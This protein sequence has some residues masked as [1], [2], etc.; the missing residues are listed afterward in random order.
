MRFFTTIILSLMLIVSVSADVN[1]T[2]RANTAFVPDILNAE[3]SVQL[4]GSLPTLTWDGGSPVIF[5]N[6][7]G[8][9]WE[10]T[11]TLPD[12]TVGVYK[13]Y[14]N[15][16]PGIA[17][18][19]EWEHAGWEAGADRPLDLS[20][21]SGT[22]TTL[23]LQ[24]VNGFN[25]DATQFEVP[26]ETND[27]TYAFHI[28]VNMAGWEDFNPENH[29]VAIRGSNMSDWGQTGE[30]SW[31]PSFPLTVEAPHA[32]GGSQNYNAANFYSGTVHVPNT[33]ADAGVQFKFVVHNTGA[34]LG[35]DWGLMAYNTSVDY[36][37]ATTGADT[38][39]YWKWFDNLEPAG[40]SGADTVDV[41]FQA[42]LTKA[43]AGNG[44]SIGDSII[45][46]AGYF[47]TAEEVM[48]LGLVRQGF[49]NVYAVTVEDMVVD[50]NN[51]TGLYYQYYKSSGGVEF[52]EVYFN[53]AYEGNNNSEAERRNI[54][55]TAD[56]Q[57]IADDMDSNVDSR[58]QPVFQN[59]GILSQNVEV[60][61]TLDLRPAYW[62]V[63]NGKTLTDGQGGLHITNHEQIDTMGVS[64]NGPATG[65]WTSWGGELHNT[66]AKQLWDDGTHGD[67]V[68][69]DSVY[70]V[71]FTYGPD[72][73]QNTIGQEFKFGIGGGDNESGYGLNHIENIDD[74]QATFTMAN[75][76]GSI[77]PVFYGWWDYDTNT[78]L[79]VTSV[80]DVVGPYAFQL[81]QNY[82]NP[83]NPT[84][85]ID[86]TVASAGKVELVV[87]NAL[88]QEVR[89]L[90]SSNVTPGA[91][92]VNW[93][94]LDNA[95]LRVSSGLYIYKITNGTQSISKKML[96]LK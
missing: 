52:R 14:T 41:T 64:M 83:F 5:T 48:S 16:Q 44:F 60:T 92:S 62:H 72:S 75:S 59:T 57:V 9:Y 93:N 40:F 69:D 50:L 2:F 13:H 24:Y 67:M 53:F 84:T 90:A 74:A 26:F 91:Y 19:V 12:S 96:M 55:L 23:P 94:G 46:R 85:T 54:V 33:Y 28:R 51:A 25:G 70:A 18:G 32:N 4:R 21:F 36:P 10:V 29:V 89:H 31:G 8:D 6:V 63:L 82:P 11:V 87:Y 77:N 80:D 95:G 37:N 79:A 68:A 73:T 15:S 39:V 34:D 22:D 20:T 86:F 66:E 30:L 65:G 61:Y 1:V 49:S 78:P 17:A 56:G 76:W 42:D 43:I 7:G 45:V 35:E 38:T 71:I 3:S 47:G 27:S 58:R 81:E 88:G